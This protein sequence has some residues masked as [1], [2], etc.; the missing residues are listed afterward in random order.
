MKKTLLTMLM[1]SS[2]LFLT[3]CGSDNDNSITLAPSNDVPVNNIQDPVVGIPIAYIDTAY[4]DPIIKNY[5][6][7]SN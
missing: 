5:D 7:P 4:Q 2:V 6:Q 1:T 3:A